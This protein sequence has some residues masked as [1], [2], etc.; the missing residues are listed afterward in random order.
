MEQ[1]EPSQMCRSEP[2]A[3]MQGLEFRLSIPKFLLTRGLSHVAAHRFFS[4]VSCLKLRE[5]AV[6]GLPGPDW[7][8]VKVAMCGICGTDQNTVRG[9]ESFSMEPYASFPAVMG[10]ETVG[11][12][13]AR[14]D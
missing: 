10:H 9:H 1:L 4:G 14:G 11:T 2:L 12:W 5:V 13:T 3:R 8:R 6:P 7:I